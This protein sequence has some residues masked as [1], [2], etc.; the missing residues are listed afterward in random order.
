MENCATN[1]NKYTCEQCDKE[2]PSI[3]VLNDK[4]LCVDCYGEEID[5]AESAYEVYLESQATGN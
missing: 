2:S 1:M 5:R 4:G 3:Y